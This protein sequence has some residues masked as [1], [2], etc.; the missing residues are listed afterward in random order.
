MIK[1][2]IKSIINNK[3]NIKKTNCV[4]VEHT[5]INIIK[6]NNK[7]KTINFKLK[8]EHY[9]EFNIPTSFINAT[10]KYGILYV[11]IFRSAIIN[12]WILK[13]GI[14][15]TRD[16]FTRF[17]EHYKNYDIIKYYNYPYIIPILLVKFPNVKMIEKEIKHSIDHDIIIG[18]NGIKFTEQTIKLCELNKI[19]YILNINIDVIDIIYFNNYYVISNS[20]II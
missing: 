16:I 3:L 9:D 14:I 5:K 13:Y 8:K 6:Q 10:N 19:I 17:N 2:I 7:Y 20:E 12:K 18:K 4:L 15:E 1:H 11:I